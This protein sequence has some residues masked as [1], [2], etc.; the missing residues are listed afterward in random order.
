M[1]VLGMAFV[2][3]SGVLCFGGLYCTLTLDVRVLAHVA[4]VVKH[5]TK[6]I[7]AGPT[8]VRLGRSDERRVRAEVV[9]DLPVF[10]DIVTLGLAAGL[11]FDAS[12]ELYCTRC[13]NTLSHELWDASLLWR[14]GAKGRGEALSDMAQRLG[15][16]ALDRFASTVCEALAF[17]TP[18]A[19]A[20]E[21]QA[22]IIRD[23]QRAAV[24]EE[25][26]KVPVKILIPLGTLIVPAMLL[27]IL[28]PLLGPAV[29]MA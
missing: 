19:Q 5:V 15:V 6:R 27:S 21:R 20:L 13:S 24:E 3:A 14:L 1:D 9:R 22:Q 29:T 2:V 18:L 17:G 23:E 16:P 11:S 4:N 10:L 12:V 28:G 26:E 25:I 7:R 8:V